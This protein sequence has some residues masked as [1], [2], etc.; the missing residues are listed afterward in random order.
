MV[1]LESPA[2]QPETAPATV[3][4]PAA[5]SVASPAVTGS[6]EVLE[7]PQD[8]PDPR[9][10]AGHNSG[11]RAKKIAQ[12]RSALNIRPLSRIVFSDS[13]V[14][15]D[16][17]TASL[18]LAGLPQELQ[19]LFKLIDVDNSG[20]IE[21]E[22]FLAFALPSGADYGRINQLWLQLL[23]GQAATIAAEVEAMKDSLQVVGP[24]RPVH[25]PLL[26]DSGRMVVLLTRAVPL[27]HAVLPA[28]HQR[29]GSRGG[30]VDAA[31]P[32]GHGGRGACSLH[33]SFTGS[34]KR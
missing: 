17:P 24:L 7:S 25:L 3:R 12:A 31:C 34:G 6:V 33:Q 26:S 1:L 9:S 30:D 8:G 4:G 15:E 18:Q 20:S 19:E 27:L 16:P 14:D 5:S 10:L 22:E 29:C 23:S 2:S 11:V 32:A 28:G 13:A 21:W